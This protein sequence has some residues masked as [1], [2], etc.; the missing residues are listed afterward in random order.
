MVRSDQTDDILASDDEDAAEEK[1]KWEIEANPDT[2]N[3][4]NDPLSVTLPNGLSPLLST[5][6][7]DDPTA[8]CRPVC[9]PSSTASDSPT[10]VPKKR[11]KIQL[12]TENGIIK[13]R[14]KI[15]K[16][17]ERIERVK[18]EI[19]RATSN[20]VISFMSLLSKNERKKLAIKIIKVLQEHQ[21]S[22]DNIID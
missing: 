20:S 7:S 5:Y 19:I 12:E 11:K 13:T 6:S 14:E 15:K 3:A 10:P 22:T 17:F 2:I 1:S 18:D 4:S 9:T 16:P 21:F 8:L